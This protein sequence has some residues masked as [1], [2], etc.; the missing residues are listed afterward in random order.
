[1]D[2]GGDGFLVVEEK[3]S[4]KSC[5]SGLFVDFLPPLRS[6]LSGDGYTKNNVYK[7]LQAGNT[8]SATQNE[9]HVLVFKAFICEINVAGM[10]SFILFLVSQRKHEFTQIIGKRLPNMYRKH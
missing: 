8:V 9:I 1:M 6:A 7:S 10:R 2:G 3:V 5:F 4:D